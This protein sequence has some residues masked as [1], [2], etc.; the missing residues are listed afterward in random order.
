MINLLNDIIL[1]FILCLA[2]LVTRD[3]VRSTMA[4]ISGVLEGK[5]LS[6]H[7]LGRERRKEARLTERS[8]RRVGDVP[9]PLENQKSIFDVLYIYNLL[10]YISM[11]SSGNRPREGAK[12]ILDLLC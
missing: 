3:R 8:A 12:L 4:L 5:R 1:E 11:V 10:I 2:L 9:S 7:E 6:H